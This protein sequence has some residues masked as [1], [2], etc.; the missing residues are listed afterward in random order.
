MTVA[1]PIAALCLAAWL[2]AAP[3][4]MA[5]P[6]G[7]EYLPQ[8]PKG[9]NHDSGRSDSG[10][11]GSGGSSTTPSSVAPT[12]TDSTSSS[13]STQTGGSEAKKHRAAKPKR[14]KPERKGAPVNLAPVSAD[15]AGGGG[16][17]PVALLLMLGAG[18]L[19][20]GIVLRRQRERHLRHPAESEA[21]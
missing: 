11:G 10:S 4:V 1:R 18:I 8:V 21:T 7:S 15:T 12:I 14:E 2:V 16:V 3:A 20:A 9:S 17:L 5:A 6:A 13:G 19:V